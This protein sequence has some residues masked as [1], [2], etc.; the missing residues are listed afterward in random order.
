MLSARIEM[1][2]MLTTGLLMTITTDPVFRVLFGLTAGTNKLRHQIPNQ[3]AETFAGIR[4]NI[5]N[6]AILK[7]L[8]DKLARFLNEYHDCDY[9][10]LDLPPGPP[11]ELYRSDTDVHGVLKPHQ[12]DE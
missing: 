9:L 10:S 12:V 1:D 3:T 6:R 11:L 5:W 2:A 7:Y 4:T 8:P